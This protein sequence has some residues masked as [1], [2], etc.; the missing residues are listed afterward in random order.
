MRELPATLFI[1]W[2]GWLGIDVQVLVL[3]LKLNQ[4]VD[5]NTNE[6]S[7][8]ARA[9]LNDSTYRFSQCAT[10]SSYTIVE[11]KFRLGPTLKVDASPSAPRKSDTDLQLMMA[12]ARGTESETAF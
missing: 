8:A 1:L 6:E 12:S 5:K 4:P 7:P 11:W 3:R 2:G 10:R 9:S